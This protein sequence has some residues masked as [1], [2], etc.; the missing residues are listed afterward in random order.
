MRHPIKSEASSESTGSSHAPR[1]PASPSGHNRDASAA[2]QTCQLFDP[3]KHNLVS[4][5]TAQAQA[6][7][8]SGA[9]VSM[10]W[11]HPF[12]LTLNLRS[13]FSSSFTLSFGTTDGSLHLPSLIT[14][15]VKN[16]GQ[17]YKYQLKKLYRDIYHPS[18]EIHHLA[19]SREPQEESRIV[20]KNGQEHVCNSASSLKPRTSLLLHSSSSIHPALSRRAPLSLTAHCPP[21]REPPSSPS[22]D[23]SCSPHM[24][25]PRIGRTKRKGMEHTRWME[26]WERW[27]MSVTRR[28]STVSSLAFPGSLTQEHPSCVP[29]HKQRGQSFSTRS[30]Y[31]PTTFPAFSLAPLS[32]PRQWCC[33]SS[34]GPCRGPSTVYSGALTLPPLTTR[35]GKTEWNGTER[36]KERTRRSARGH[37]MYVDSFFSLNPLIFSLIPFLF[38]W[39][40]SQFC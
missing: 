11:F 3:R 38:C 32:R 16:P 2:S 17:F 28:E 15:L 35:I 7:K 39:F 20:I 34:R 12:P 24:T 4:S 8:S 13:A 37:E 29:A 30:G 18:L 26:Q 21:R 14:S 25:T 31:T 6:S 5:S 40:P 19:D 22:V 33:P 36:T 9:A 23:T 1:T 10:F 27:H